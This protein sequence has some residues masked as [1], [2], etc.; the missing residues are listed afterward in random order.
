MLGGTKTW[1]TRSMW[2]TSQLAPSRMNKSLKPQ[3]YLAGPHSDHKGCLP[4]EIDVAVQYALQRK[5]IHY[6]P[7]GP[8]SEEQMSPTHTD[9]FKYEW[10]C[11]V[12]TALPGAG[13]ANRL[14][15]SDDL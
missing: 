6:R 14:S 2:P 13:L 11:L 5:H 15:F 1:C 9:S 4:S 3:E 8:Q 12:R 7:I 10:D